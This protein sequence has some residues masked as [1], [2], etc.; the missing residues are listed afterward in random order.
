MVYLTGQMTVAAMVFSVTYAGLALRNRNWLRI[1]LWL[2]FLVGGAL[3]M[4]TGLVSPQEAQGAI[5]LR[6]ITFLFSMF[7][8]TAGL[9][10]SGDLQRFSQ[11]IT[12]GARS[13]RQL[14]LM[15]AFGF[16]LASSLLMNDTV[17]LMATPLLIG[18]ARSLGVRAKPL[19]LTLAF[20]ISI[21]SA[22]TPIGNPQNMV[23]ALQGG[24]PSP[25]LTFVYFLLPSTLINLLLLGLFVDFAFGR[26]LK[27]RTSR[28]SVEEP[29]V[30]WRLSLSSRV[31]LAMAVGGMVLQNMLSIYGVYS[32][33]GISE[34]A[35]FSAVFLL[36]VSPRRREIMGRVNWGL[37]V[38]FAGLFVFSKGIYNSGLVGAFGSLSQ[39]ASGLS[40]LGF[41]VVSS[42]A[43]SQVI[44]NVP[45]VTMLV[46][47]YAS[48]I[49]KGSSVGWAA[50]AGAS[51]LAGNVSLV[52]AARNLII[53]EEA[54]KEGESI[55][56][57]EFLRYGLPLSAVNL[58]V[59]L[60]T[61]L[62][63][64]L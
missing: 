55:G 19:L 35:F 43:L 37:I 50:L 57:F 39:P 64:V 60:G 33:F 5:D 46:P 41:I 18:V 32:P 4:A 2:V 31:A 22:M 9:Q 11:R 12:K 8:I 58:S 10:L 20:A 24:V 59:L 34:I 62:P 6:V 49:P 61:L 27:F 53:V 28:V 52:G 23:I 25:F 48:V 26:S 42:V 16:G 45:L 63:Y 40:S 36:T 47:L 54:E 44:S 7:V 56:F 21:G 51:T 38:M 14:I 30:D 17:A 13:P 3:M 29:K 1:P 15:V